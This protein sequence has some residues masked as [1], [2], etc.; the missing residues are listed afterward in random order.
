MTANILY[1]GVCVFLK[2]CFIYCLMGDSCILGTKIQK[3][4]KGV[5]WKQ[6]PSDPVPILKAVAITSLCELLEFVEAFADL[7]E[8]ELPEAAVTT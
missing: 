4:Q 5:N 3:E 8:Y 1:I 2:F 6:C 7:W